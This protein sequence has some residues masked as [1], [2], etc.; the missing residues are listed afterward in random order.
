MQ[1]PI[2]TE[3]PK[4]QKHVEDAESFRSLVIAPGMLISWLTLERAAYIAL[5]LLAL[6]LR[7]ANLGVHPLS[8]AE[9]SQAL[10]AWHMY[11]G[12]PVAQGGYSP[13]MATLNLVSFALLGAT[14]FAARIGPALLGMALVLLPYGLRRHL[15]RN[16]ALIAAALFAIS[17]TTVYFS[18]TVNGDIGAAL[19]GLALTVGLFNWLDSLRKTQATDHQQPD[20]VDD[21]SVGSVAQAPQALPMSSLYL[22]AIGLVLMLTASPAAY[23]ILVLLLA[24]LA[25]AAAV[26][27]K[28]YAAAA[29]AG[30]VTMR[31]RLVGWGN[32]GLGVLIGLLAIATAFLVNLGGLTATADLLTSWLLGFAPATAQ[33]GAYPAVFLLTLYEPLILLAGLF[34]LSAGLLRR[35][36]IDLFLGWWFFGSIALN[37]LRSGRTNSAVLVP[38]VPLTLL[39]GLALGMLWDSLRKEAS[40]Q[41]EGMLAVIGLIISG[42]TYISLMTYTLSGGSTVWLPVAA[43]VLF[44]GLVAL[45]W[46]W[47]DGAAA[48]RGGALVVVIVL[49]IFTIATGS[50]LNYTFAGVGGGGEPVSN[51]RQPLI[52]TPGGEGLNDLLDTLKQISSWEAGDAHLLPII[53]DRRLGPV[54]E[55]ALHDFKN[56]TWL[57][58]LQGPSPE[59]SS[60]LSDKGD[61]TVLLAPADVK[62]S[63]DGSYA[64]QS[65]AV[66]EYWVP[67][68]LNGQSLIRWIVLRTASTPVTYDPVVLWVKLPQTTPAEGQPIPSGQ[69]GN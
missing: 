57:D 20:S 5:A 12:L 8:D 2:I 60:A 6:G 4:T 63:L 54:V 39:A 37:L 50:R 43:V 23:S 17:P 41:K 48:L 59:L 19:G 13:L 51:P 28:S 64:G 31:Q 15:G 11:Q 35:R 67:A 26:G 24:F 29:Q 36:L 25:L 10:V 30:L 55:W 53:A 45:F 52:S 62:L 14:D 68:G 69:S 66:R 61:T 16:G 33:P 47:Y 18:R 56:V 22:A 1:Q 9:A 44:L 65:F 3:T 32:F 27:D 49:A 34:G 7:L 42:Y 40:W 58:S 21:A 46:I 38:L